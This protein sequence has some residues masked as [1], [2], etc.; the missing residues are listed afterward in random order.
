MYPFKR[1]ALTKKNKNI[2]K[3]LWA[4]IADR[5]LCLINTKWQKL[6]IDHN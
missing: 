3:D 1:N 4:N 6:T 5:Q 2:L